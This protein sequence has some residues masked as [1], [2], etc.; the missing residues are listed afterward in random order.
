MFPL[1]CFSTRDPGDPPAMMVAP[2]VLRTWE[3]HPLRMA[4]LVT[5]EVQIAFTSNVVKGRK[6]NGPCLVVE[7]VEWS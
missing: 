5:H 1:R 3:I 6:R 7:G 4:K 2:T